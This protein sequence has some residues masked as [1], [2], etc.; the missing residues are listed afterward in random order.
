[1]SNALKSAYSK[2]ILPYEVWLA[3]HK[4]DQANMPAATSSGGMKRV[5]PPQGR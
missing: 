2:V 3:K 4:Q 5:T 1:M